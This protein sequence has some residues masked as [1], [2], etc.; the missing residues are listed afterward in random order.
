MQTK[1]KKSITKPGLAALSLAALALMATPVL[2]GPYPTIS[3]PGGNFTIPDLTIT[4]LKFLSKPLQG[5]CNTMLIMVRNKGDQSS[6]GV[7]VSIAT[8]LQGNSPGSSFQQ[9]SE[10]KI[11]VPALKPG[12]SHVKKIQN[13]SILP[14]GNVTVMAQ[15]YIQPQITSPNTYIVPATLK[16]ITVLGSCRGS[17]ILPHKRK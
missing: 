9:R 16:Y 11:F 13:I 17:L 4:K 5:N 8:F 7:K 15:I 1:D 12:K 6:P 3:V 2:A 10:R 14:M